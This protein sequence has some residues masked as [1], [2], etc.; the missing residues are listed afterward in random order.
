MADGPPGMTRLER[1]SHVAQ[2]VSAVAVIVSIVYLAYQIRENTAA[3]GFETS[4]GL[5]ELQFQQDEWDQDPALVELMIRGDSLPDSL[6]AV[7][8]AQYSRRWALRWNVWSVAHTGFL[9]GT[10]SP[11]IWDGWDRSYSDVCS[12]G[13]RRFRAEHMH[14]WSEPFQRLVAAH[15]ENC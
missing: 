10:L 14:W 13:V 3:V 7:E 1:A 4:R 15:V 5:V 11:E 6:S 9:Q 2:I 12:L 8:W